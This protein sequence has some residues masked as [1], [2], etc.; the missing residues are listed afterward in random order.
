MI[1]LRQAFVC[2]F[3][4]MSIELALGALTVS[5]SAL[6]WILVIHKL[7]DPLEVEKRSDIIVRIASRSHEKNFKYYDFNASKIESNQ[8]LCE[9]YIEWTRGCA[10]YYRN[11]IDSPVTALIDSPVTALI[12]SP[13]TALIHSP[14]TALVYSVY[15][16][17]IRF[18]EYYINLCRQAYRW[19]VRQRKNISPRKSKKLCRQA[20]RWGVRQRN[21]IS[22]RKS[23]KDL[24]FEQWLKKQLQL[25]E[26]SSR[27]DRYRPVRKW[28]GVIRNLLTLLICTLAAAIIWEV[29][30]KAFE[31]GRAADTSKGISFVS[32]DGIWEKILIFSFFLIIVMVIVD[33]FRQL[34]QLAQF[35]DPKYRFTEVV[36]DRTATNEEL[37]H[38]RELF[39]KLV[40]CHENS[41][42]QRIGR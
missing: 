37:R 32:L 28:F 30:W 41:P 12:H 38:Y 16:Y 31:D 39:D 33:S 24:L 11:L 25:E 35:E 22:P 1:S 29:F 40:A 9:I 26:Y 14:V 10:F 21:N 42:S 19:G 34:G 8:K 6:G 5:F 13:V 3:A 36:R 27:G 15:E 17:P 7:T 4:R 20:Y 18:I 2:K 23:K